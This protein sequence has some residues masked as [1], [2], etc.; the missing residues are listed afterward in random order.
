MA[1]TKQNFLDDQVLTAA[2]LNH[3]EDGIQNIAGRYYTSLP[4]ALAD[5]KAGVTTGAADDD[6]G[7]VV[8]V[9]TDDTKAILTLLQDVTQA[10]QLVID[11]DVNLVLNGHTLA[12]SYAGDNITVAQG[13]IFT[14]DG[15]TDGSAV[16]LIVDGLKAV[17]V[18]AN[19][20]LTVNGGS[21]S[22]SCTNG[23][24]VAFASTAACPQMALYNCDISTE[25]GSG[26]A[27]GVQSLSAV[28]VHDGVELTANG[29]TA[30]PILH[31]STATIRNTEIIATGSAQCIG[32]SAH[33][34]SNTMLNGVT[35]LAKSETRDAYGIEIQTGAT[36][37][38][39]GINITAVTMTAKEDNRTAV[40]VYNSGTCILEDSFILADAKGEIPEG[41]SSV[42]ILSHGTM[43]CIN[44]QSFGTHNALQNNGDLYADRCLL[45][46]V[47]HGGL[48]TTHTH[49]KEV[50]VNDTVIEVG[51]YR[52][53]FADIYADL[54][55]P[56]PTS[57]SVS[58]LSG[59]YFGNIDPYQDGGDLYMD[60]C[61]FV[62]LG[63][64]S[65][66]VRPAAYT[67]NGVL[68]SGQNPNRLFISRSKI[69]VRRNTSNVELYG[70]TAP[71]RL[72]KY[73]S[74]IGTA[75]FAEIH[76]GTGCNFTADNL[77]DAE[78]A[79]YLH[80]AEEFYR[81]NDQHLP[82]YEEYYAMMKEE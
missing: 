40:G 82:T 9:N 59:M 29:A 32:L 19:D 14:I 51:V 52:G 6:T 43:T 39:N 28:L 46:G 50:V 74:A 53:Q 3:M 42:G 57:G 37:S 31:M 81:K 15:T 60:G 36:L 1:Y 79:Q 17:L 22:V 10:G 80:G 27:T 67:T 44:T 78:A 72:N 77:G 12:M 66:V 73:N 13:S 75:A 58:A 71:I 41:T 25:S 70:Q 54:F 8:R 16:K 65:F 26:T 21:Y 20:S 68:A 24:A 49:D 61:I 76:Q 2:N 30:T 63:G 48:Y 64:E 18:R 45:S 38:A 62:G 47:S 7:A 56:I 35:V 11:T 69:A 55:R 23:S 34:N 4:Q 33:P 5:I